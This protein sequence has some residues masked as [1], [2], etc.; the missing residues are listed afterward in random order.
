MFSFVEVID[1]PRKSQSVL[2]SNSLKMSRESNETQSTTITTNNSH[3]E[4]RPPIIS[5]P[6]SP[7]PGINDSNHDSQQHQHSQE[8]EQQ[9]QEHE[10]EE[11]K[12][13]SQFIINKLTNERTNNFI[14]GES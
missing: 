6:M 11:Q 1:V 2:T 7:I 13:Q 14:E 9:E 12:N 5:P 8:E 3:R 4:D 10:H